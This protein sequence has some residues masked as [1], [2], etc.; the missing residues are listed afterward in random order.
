M[1]SDIG[2][3]IMQWQG[4]VSALKVFIAILVMVKSH[5]KP[6]KGNLL[7]REIGQTPKK[8]TLKEQEN[9]KGLLAALRAGPA[10]LLAPEIGFGSKVTT[11]PL[12]K[13]KM[14]EV[15]TAP[16][17]SVWR[18]TAGSAGAHGLEPS[19]LSLILGLLRC[20][21]AR[22]WL[23]KGGPRSFLKIRAEVFDQ[24]EKRA[25]CNP[26]QWVCFQQNGQFVGRE[27]WPPPS[28]SLAGKRQLHRACLPACTSPPVLNLH[29]RVN[30][31]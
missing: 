29:C 31:I 13:D 24:L 21:A 4:I 26:S 20:R 15:M 7:Q 14:R 25:V 28:C 23:T 16:P 22:M 12:A 18:R 30:G 17:R 8:E 2:K 3:L 9:R 19:A 11:H 5:G 27:A 10:A 6:A 1:E